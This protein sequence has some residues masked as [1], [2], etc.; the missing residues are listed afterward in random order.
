[1]GGEVDASGEIGGGEFD[2]IF[3]LKQILLAGEDKIAY[4]FAK[5]FFEYA[6]GYPPGLEERLQ[7]WDFIT[8]EPEHRQ[9]RTLL[10]EILAKSQK[11]DQ[12]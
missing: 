11:T 6:N 8:S 9:L 3:G 5:K 4:N 12:P 2:D 10:T 1:M 7:L